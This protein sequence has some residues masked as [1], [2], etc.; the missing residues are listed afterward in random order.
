MP[1]LAEQR[2]SLEEFHARYDGQKPYHE[3]W[4]GAAVAKAM[5]TRLHALVQKILVRMLDDLGYEAEQEV[6][7][8]LDSHYEPIPDVV[9]AEGQV[10]DPYPIE[11]FEVAIEIL[12]SEDAFSRVAK[13]CRL[14]AEWGIRQVVVIDPEDRVIWRSENGTLSPSAVVATR[15]D[16]VITA[17]ALWKEVDLHLRP[18]ES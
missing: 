8:K 14:Y 3:Y 11:A 16:R 15:G 17:E 12:S 4:N 2:L 5:P 1:A 18:R 6:T 9:A 10:G 7:V 13:K